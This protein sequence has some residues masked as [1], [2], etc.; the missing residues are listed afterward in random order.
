PASHSLSSESEISEA[1][2]GGRGTERGSPP[3]LPYPVGYVPGT[4]TILIR[5][6]NRL[7]SLEQVWFLSMGVV[8]LLQCSVLPA[9][10]G[11]CFP[12]SAHPALESCDDELASPL[13][14]PYNHLKQQRKMSPKLSPNRPPTFLYVKALHHIQRVMADVVLP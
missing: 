6:K 13:I 2:A 7:A 10:S 4:D 9:F 11:V 14:Q 5:P 3:P 12:S 1:G 8:P